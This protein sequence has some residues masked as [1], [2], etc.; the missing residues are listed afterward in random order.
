MADIKI[1]LSPFSVPNYVLIEGP[2]TNDSGIQVPTY[3]L[4]QLSEEALAELCDEFRASVFKKAGKKDP[5][6]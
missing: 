3:A 6:G 4:N 2:S 5:N 1:K